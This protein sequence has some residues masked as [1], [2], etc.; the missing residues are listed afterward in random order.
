M[1]DTTAIDYGPFTDLI[2]VWEGQDGIDI[3]PYP[4]GKETNPFYEEIIY[5]AVGGVTNAES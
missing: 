4:D 1:V 2:G 3:A 5:S